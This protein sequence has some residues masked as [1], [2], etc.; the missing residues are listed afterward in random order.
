MGGLIFKAGDVVAVFL[1]AADYGI[2]GDVLAVSANQII[3]YEAIV[4]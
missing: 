3:P 1:R 4:V 2:Q